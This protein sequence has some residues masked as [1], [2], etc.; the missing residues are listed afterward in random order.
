M[1]FHAKYPLFDSQSDREFTFS[2]AILQNNL[3][4][5]VPTGKAVTVKRV[6]SCVFCLFTFSYQAALLSWISSLLEK[7]QVVDCVKYCTGIELHWKKNQKS[8]VLEFA[9]I[10]L[11]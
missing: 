8:Y 7:E 1:Q 4:K 3:H 2:Y 5:I 6:M 10:Q 11:F 9:L